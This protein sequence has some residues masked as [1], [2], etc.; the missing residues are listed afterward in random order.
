MASFPTPPLF[1]ALAQGEP[2]RIS[3]WTYPPKTRGMSL[4]Y[5]IIS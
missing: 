4:P 3:G 2:I 5:G 1:G